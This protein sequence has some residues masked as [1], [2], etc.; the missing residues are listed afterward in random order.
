MEDVRRFEMKANAELDK[1]FI[2]F[3]VFCRLFT[4]EFSIC[5]K[6]I[7]EKFVDY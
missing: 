4:V 6:E 5:S 2:L 3:I 7:E 1:V